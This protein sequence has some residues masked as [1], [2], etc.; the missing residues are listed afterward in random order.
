MFRIFKRLDTLLLMAV[1]ALFVFSVFMIFSASL[2]TATAQESLLNVF[3]HLF[4]FFIGVLFC[5]FFV[6]LNYKTLTRF[7]WILYILMMGT[8]LIVLFYG[9]SAQGAQRWI[10]LGFF[11]FQPSEMAKL[12]VIISLA[13]LLSWRKQP[14]KSLWDLMPYAMLVGIPF[15]LIAKQPDL[16]TAL[17]FIF[18]FLAML[19]LTKTSSD[20][21]CLMASPLL[22]LA[23]YHFLPGG[24][25]FFWGVY[26]LGFL[27]ITSQRKIPWFERLVFLAI[28]IGAV[29]VVPMGW[30]FLKPYQ[31]ERLLVFIDPSIDPLARGIRYHI[32]KSVTAIGSG[33]LW[34]QGWLQGGLTHLQYIPVQ[35]SDFIFAVI[36]EEFGLLGGI[37][38]FALMGTLIYRSFRIAQTANDPFGS[39]LAVGIGAFFLVQSVINI[40]MTV[41]VMP[42][43][44]IPL[45]FLSFGGSALVTNLAAL[46]LLQS[47]TC[48]REKLYF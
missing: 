44:G 3:K 42:V 18:M 24:F 31:Q 16:G 13:A 19:V 4:S 33:G 25:H 6:L 22:S 38:V 8:L 46:G 43:V 5:L 29:W 30:H 7:W 26:L 39:L 14:I 1:G 34:G 28:N 2:G 36:G 9:H 37:F 32:D 47:I 35:K 45:P 40:G 12:I 15:L 41:G 21:L 17:V 48:R 23:I 10:N 11:V 27:W 20:L